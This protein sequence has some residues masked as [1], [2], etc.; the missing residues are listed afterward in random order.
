MIKAYVRGDL[1]RELVD[2]NVI[3]QL[4]TKA[5]K[6]CGAMRNEFL[7]V[8]KKMK[9]AKNV[10][11]ALEK[12]KA[13]EKADELARQLLA[14]VT[15]SKEETAKLHEALQQTTKIYLTSLYETLDETL[16][17]TCGMLSGDRPRLFYFLSSEG[18]ELLS[19]AVEVEDGTMTEAKKD[20]RI[21]G[22]QANTNTFSVVYFVIL[23]LCSLC[24]VFYVSYVVYCILCAVFLWRAVISKDWEAKILDPKHEKAKEDSFMADGGALL[25][26]IR[27]YHGACTRI[28]LDQ[29]RSNMTSIEYTEEKVRLR[30]VHK[31]HQQRANDFLETNPP[32]DAAKD[33]AK[34]DSDGKDGEGKKG[35]TGKNGKKGKKGKSWSVAKLPDPNLTEDEL[36]DL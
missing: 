23:Q 11:D 35:Q 1:D 5:H 10:E 6:Y 22:N 8:T 15:A 2:V 17:E 14:E 29:W 13:E 16:Y 7:R 31:A 19:N 36:K 20:Q 12:L 34:D 25:E 9:Q 4:P 26:A 18:C 21:A 33:D 28:Q 32:P 27:I 24:F 3:D 30:H